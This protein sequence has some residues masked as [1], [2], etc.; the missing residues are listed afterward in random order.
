MRVAV[1]VSLS[2]LAILPASAQAVEF[3]RPSYELVTVATQTFFPTASPGTANEGTCL[4]LNSSDVPVRVR[5]EVAVVYADG[6]ADRLSRIQDPGVL[7]RDGG[8]ELSVLFAIPPSTPLGAA[9]FTCEVSAQ[10][11]VARKEHEEETSVAAFDIV[12][13]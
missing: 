7:E 6:R 3:A 8:F 1:A 9:Q 2:S 12:A 13:P 11:L 5:M 4:V 10:S